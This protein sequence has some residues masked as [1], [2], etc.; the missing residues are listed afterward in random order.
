[1]DAEPCILGGKVPKVQW[2][3]TE[4]QIQDVTPELYPAVTQSFNFD[5]ENTKISSLYTSTKE[6]KDMK[7]IL[8]RF[9]PQIKDIYQYLSALC[10]LNNIFCIGQSVFA[11]FAKTCNLVDDR[12]LKISDVDVIFFTMYTPLSKIQAEAAKA[13]SKY[14]LRS[15]FIEAL[16]K[17]SNEKFIKT[18]CTNSLS[19]AYE[20]ILLEN[21]LPNFGNIEGS[22]WKS[23]RFLTEKC[24]IVV[25]KH[26][27]ILEHL[28]KQSINK[29]PS[30]LTIPNPPNLIFYR[31][32]LNLIFASEIVN[33]IFTEKDVNVAFR[34]SLG[35]HNE[36]L[37][38]E[39][40][41]NMML[42]YNEFIESIARIA[43]K[44]GLVPV[45][46]KD[47]DM[48]WTTK[49]RSVLPLHVKLEAILMILLKKGCNKEFIKGY[50]MVEKSEFEEDINQVFL[51]QMRG[52]AI[53]V[54]K[55]LGIKKNENKTY[56]K[57]YLQKAINIAILMNKVTRNLMRHDVRKNEVDT[58]YHLEKSG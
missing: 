4:P 30:G 32:F 55:D 17:I 38:A 33:K 36:D 19:E 1:M 22:Q 7:A 45:G 5:Y 10:P 15:Q 23:T 31:D 54:D 12:F 24:E 25:K 50:K 29:K 39:Y 20:R 42:N 34:M 16:V 2:R 13:A 44:A 26:W 58:P 6:E 27:T 28:Y 49:L 18:G 56:M 40:N 21:V 3:D 46:E 43:E 9:Y 8:L 53:Y 37:N 47:N 41:R 57:N 11:E 51:A 48:K 52:S 35:F 14:L